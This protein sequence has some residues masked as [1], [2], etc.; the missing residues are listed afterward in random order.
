MICDRYINY[1]AEI[2]IKE[3]KV[4]EKELNQQKITKLVYTGEKFGIAH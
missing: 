2:K 3:S 1:I 4:L